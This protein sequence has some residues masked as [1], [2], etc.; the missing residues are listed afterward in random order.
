LATSQ[1][2]SRSVMNQTFASRANLAAG[3]ASTYVADIA[4]R[5]RTVATARLGADVTPDRFVQVAT[6]LGFEA[7]VLLDE[8]GRVL[9][10]MP[11]NPRVIG[12][13]VATKYRHLAAAE[14][15]HIGVS[16]VV[17]GLATGHPLVG[18]AVQFSA[19]T[20]KRVFSGG[21][22]IG[23][24]PLGAYLRN[25][26]PYRGATSELIDQSGNV[27]ASSRGSATR[28]TLKKT[29]AA[30]ATAWGGGDSGAG[31]F[32]DSVGG[33]R[34]VA[35][36]LAGTPWTLVNTVTEASLYSSLTGIGSWLPWV[37]LACLLLAGVQASVLVVRLADSKAASART[38]VTDSLTT[39]PNRRAW[40][41]ELPKQL[42]RARRTQTPICMAVLDIDKFKDFNDT[43]GHRAG[44]MLLTKA[45]RAWAEHLRNT[46]LIVRYGGEEFGV[47]L[48]GTSADDAVAVIERVRAATPD[49]CT[50]SVGFAQWDGIESPAHLFDRADRAL[51]RAKSA[52]RNRS[53]SD[54]I[55]TRVGLAHLQT[56]S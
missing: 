30:L 54:P 21:F 4:Q 3:F 8:D 37:V 10:V 29:D 32:S 14:G 24:T 13:T 38:A 33:H 47:L 40:G 42:A 12:T 55:D 31:K 53:V 56:A 25:S 26:L 23:T 48:P 5:E 16:G 45:A 6:D 35:L 43:F 17:P 22:N 34:F 1:D 52:G 46:D 27:V 15:G 50:A 44:D 28:S 41:V 19:I 2:A 36:R 39:L 7:A 18:I 49:S 51:Y 20:G 11:S 9:A